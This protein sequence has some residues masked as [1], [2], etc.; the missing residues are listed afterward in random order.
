MQK[1]T[2][3]DLFSGAGG[4]SLGLDAAGFHN[5][6]AVDIEASYCETYRAN[7]PHH[8]LIQQDVKQITA[9]ELNMIIA[10]R[11][12]DVVIGGPPC[13]GFSIAGSIGR[14]FI[15]DPR[16]HLFQEFARIVEIVKPNYFVMENVARLY[17]HQNGATR[18][19]IIRLFEQLGYHV[20]C[21]VLNTANFGVAQVRNRVFFIGN[22]RSSTIFFPEEN[23]ETVKTVAQCIGHLPPLESS[24]H[25][26]LANHI[27][28]KHS[29][30]M[31]EKM[32][33]VEDGGTREQIPVHLRPATGDVRKYIRYKSDQPSICVTGDMRKVFHY[34]QNRALTVREL[35]A[36]Q[37]FPDDFIFK[38][39]SIS[40]QQQVGN[41]V[42][43]IMAN[44]IA[45]TILK[46]I[47]NDTKTLK[48]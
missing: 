32:K 13:Q 39:N 4:F 29:Q 5:C 44:I 20:A 24:E 6:C 47:E 26:K 36:L 43:P 37:S 35:A 8:H 30:Q 33:Y 2:Y 11:Q 28:M 48:I 25:S 42:P 18:R 10:G 16:N 41:A 21:K 27:A 40:Q 23:K 34:Q 3:I 12:I 1:P 15:D 14:K 17:T 45:Q 7:F 31:L 19:E 38:G 9:K 22:K 46:M